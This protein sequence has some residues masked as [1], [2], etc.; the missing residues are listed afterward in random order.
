MLLIIRPGASILHGGAVFALAARGVLCDLPDAHPHAARR[1]S[2][3][4][5]VL[6]GAVRQRADAA[7]ACLSSTTAPTCRGVDIALIGLT[8]I[9]GTVGPFPVHPRVP[10]RAGLGAHP[11][12]LHP[13]GLGDPAGLALLR[14]VPGCADARGHRGDRRERAS[15]RVARAAARPRCGGRRGAARS[16]LIRDPTFARRRRA[17]VR[18]RPWARPAA[19]G[20][21]ISMD[22]GTHGQ[23]DEDAHRFHRTWPHGSRHGEESRHQGLPADGHRAPQ[24]RAARGHSRGRRRGSEV[25]RR[26]RR[27]AATS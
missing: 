1:R 21:C 16:R 4:D 2:A 9:L 14:P 23:R 13:A 22:G 6:P 24:S 26:A 19:V 17:V 10:A 20:L 8:G 11:V 15:S 25:A 27:A 18:F 7:G 12:H 3:R 5:A